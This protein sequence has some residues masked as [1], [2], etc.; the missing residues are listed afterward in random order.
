MSGTAK[1]LAG[2]FVGSFSLV[3][4]CSGGV[5]SRGASGNSTSPDSGGNPADVP[6]GA[7]PVPGTDAAPGPTFVPD[8]GL[9]GAPFS[10]SDPSCQ[11]SATQIFCSSV[12]YSVVD[13]TE[14]HLD[15]YAPLSALTQKV[16]VIMYVHGGGW[17]FGSYH[18]VL[19]T[20]EQLQQ[21]R[22]VVSVEYRLTLLPDRVTP[23]GVVFPMN[24]IDVKTAVRWLRI[25]GS[26]F[27]DGS[28]ILAYGF[29]AGAHLASVLA[30]S[31]KVAAFEGRGDLSV[32]TTVKAAVALSAAFDFHVFVPTNPPLDP[33]CA[34]LNKKPGDNPQ[35]LVPILVGLTD[36]NDPALLPR[37]DVLSSVT[38]LDADTPPMITF[39]GTCDQTQPYQ[40]TQL[41]TDT[42]AAKGLTQV[43]V[44]I[45]PMAVHGST[46]SAPA[47]QSLLQD[48]ITQQLGP[49][50]P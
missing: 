11:K 33:A 42:L 50:M 31:S 4:G 29:S 1:W 12:V 16:P 24:L 45:V 6:D 9:E 21:G 15:L 7:A 39:N 35:Q 25:K 47:Q 17:A 26:G 14:L 19:S 37:L 22:A 48:F 2:I 40:T 32:P 34:G 8:T 46:V 10:L 5:A 36:I 20:A 18:E 13:G 43:S 23:S 30:T 28:R 27:I 3:V 41:L 44:N 49:A 38:Y